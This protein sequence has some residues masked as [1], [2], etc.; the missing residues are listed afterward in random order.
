MERLVIEFQAIGLPFLAE[1]NLADFAKRV[2][3]AE[4]KVFRNKP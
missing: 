4:S 2:R 3:I 1:T